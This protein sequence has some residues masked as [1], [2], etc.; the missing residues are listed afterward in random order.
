MARYLGPKH[1]LSRRAGACVWR[2]PKSP[3][4]KR[5]YPPGQHG[6]NMRRKM[7]VYGTQL[8]EKQKLRMHYGYIVEKQ[9][10]RTFDKARSMGGNTGTNLM[11]LLE[12][13]LDTVVWRLG[14]A[15]TIFAARQ[16]V[17]HCHI[18]VDGK[19]CNIPSMQVKPGQAVSVR[20]R[21]RKIPTVMD[22]V[23]HPPMNMPEYL[24]REAKSFEG[25]MV[26]TPNAET[27]PYQVDTVSIIGFYS[28]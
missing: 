9:M 28:R 11:M 12:S 3:A 16:L 10:R 18:Q 22:G 2:N 24:S 1:K 5:P 6:Q 4:V 25:K 26:A 20:P 23:E 19:K 14:F 15:P 8:L 17:S 13:R 27:V 21:S 7:S